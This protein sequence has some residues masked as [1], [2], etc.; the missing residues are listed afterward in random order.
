MGSREV[1]GR[2]GVGR[3]GDGGRRG[4]TSH[5]ARHE[6]R[7]QIPAAELGNRDAVARFEREARSTVRIKSEYLARVFDAGTL[8]AGA[9]YMDPRGE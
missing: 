6:S 8:D 3:R 4:S 5:R 7:H 9:P 1:P 2:K